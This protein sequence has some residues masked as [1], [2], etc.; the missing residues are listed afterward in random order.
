MSCVLKHYEDWGG[1]LD[2]EH[3]LNMCESLHSVRSNYQTNKPESF[4]N[5]TILLQYP[6]KTNFKV[7][8]ETTWY[9]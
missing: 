9:H 6:K 4:S 7:T 8:T 5:E 3:M 1:W 2:M